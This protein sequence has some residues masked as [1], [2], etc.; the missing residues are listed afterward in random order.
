MTVSSTKRT[1]IPTMSGRSS[2]TD[3]QGELPSDLSCPKS[4][5]IV[6]NSSDSFTGL[7]RNPVT[8]ISL[9]FAMTSSRP[10]AVTM[11]IFGGDFNLLS[12]KMRLAD[13][14]PSVV[15]ICQSIKTRSNGRS[16]SCD[17]IRSSASSPELADSPR[18]PKGTSC[19]R[20]TSRAR[21]LSSTTSTRSPSSPPLRSIRSAIEA[22]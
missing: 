10:K 4:C 9:A 20:R 1:F 19:S 16:S 6:S 14:I 13:T 8:P 21:A 17:S 3:S 22:S 7:M 2:G 11:M 12:R 5:V 15:G 18:I